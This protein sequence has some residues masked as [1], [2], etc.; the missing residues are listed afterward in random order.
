MANA[1][2]NINITE[3][4]FDAIKTSLKSYLKNQSQFNDYDFEGSVVSTV[5]DILSYNTHYNAFYLNMVANEMFLDTALKRSSVISHAKLLNYTPK[6]AICPTAVVS[7]TF[8]GS[9]D[10]SFTL[11]KYTKF[12]SES[13]N[14]TNYPFVSLDSYTVPVS[15]GVA[16]F[17]NIVLHQGQP[18]SYTYSVDLLNNPKFVYKLPDGNIDISTLQVYVYPFAQ[19]TGYDIYNKSSTYLT[20]DNSSKVYFIQESLD[21]Y[22]ELYFGDGIL[23]AALT[24]SNVIVIEYLTTSSTQSTGA[25]KFTLMDD[26]GSYSSVAITPIQSSSGGQVKES[27]DSIKFQAPKAFSSQNRAVTKDDYITIIQQ[28]TLGL[29]FDAVNVWGGEENDVPVFGQVFISLKPT[30][31]YNITETQKQ[32]L[33]QEVIK[34]ISVLT[35]TPTIVDPDYTYLKLNVKVIFDSKKTKLTAKELE[36]GIKE[37]IISFAADTLNTFNSTF[38]SYGLLTAIQNYSSSIVTSDYTIQLQK[39]FFP[40]L[41]MPTTYKLYY[42]TPLE[43]GMFLSGVTSSPSLQFLDQT[44][45]SIIIDGVYLEEVPTSTNGVESISILN[46]GTSYQYVPT[47]T[48]VGDGTGAS[49]HAVISGGSIKSIII[50]SAGSGYT[51]AIATVTP[52]YADTTGKLGSLVVNLEGKFGTIRSYY[53]NTNNVKNV[54]DPALGTIDYLN[55]IV[56]LNSFSPFNV[57]NDLGQF[58][59]TTNPTTTIISSSYNKI[60]TIDPYDNTAITVTV[61]DKT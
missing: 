58:S 61:V 17:S 44:D 16:A 57:D 32:R 26:I 21:G 47:I 13:V 38:N 10:I 7:M 29:T 33:I 19:S 27:I 20:L 31:A 36:V 11:P 59:I 56:T 1:N 3:L 39:K 45:L 54:L 24:A 48:I 49:A 42:N 8:N 15:N 6:S 25:S 55:G 35:V 43:K 37:T 14:G 30:G 9:T 40:N 18:V 60:I 28:N 12:Y 2:S 46:P 51:A 50:D 34:P 52:Q 53:N 41:T 5:L 4:D 22:Y 23:G